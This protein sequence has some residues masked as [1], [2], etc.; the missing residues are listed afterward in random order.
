MLNRLDNEPPSTTA[1][2]SS[3]DVNLDGYISSLDA[4]LV[5]NYLNEQPS[6]GLADTTGVSVDEAW[7][8]DGYFKSLGEQAT[9]KSTLAVG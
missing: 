7:A 1:S 5:I 3:L 4:L 9:E 2:N 8:I 6:S